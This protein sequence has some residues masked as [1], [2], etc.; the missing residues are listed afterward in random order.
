T[1]TH[2]ALAYRRMVTLASS[3]SSGRPTRTLQSKK[4]NCNANLLPEF[5]MVPPDTETKSPALPLAGCARRTEVTTRLRFQRQD[6]YMQPHV[7][8]HL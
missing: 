7:A 4:S 1:K 6:S 2:T 3:A 5:L 8:T